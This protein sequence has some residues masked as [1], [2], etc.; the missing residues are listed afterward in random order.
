MVSSSRSVCPVGAVS[1]ITKW[2]FPL[3]TSWAKAVNT[4]ISS[5]Q[6]ERSS[7]SSNAL[8][9]ASKLAPL[10][11][12]VCSMCLRVV[13]AGS[14]AWTLRLGRDSRFVSLMWSAGSVVVR[15]TRC[16]FSASLRAIFL[17]SV[18]FPTPPFPIVMMTPLLDAAIFSISSS[19]FG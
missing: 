18:V 5:V 8:P 19:M 15:W 6:G 16:P 10:V 17:A 9:L 13:S 2:S 14:I 12:R 7:S 3:S 11:A 4:A 1:R